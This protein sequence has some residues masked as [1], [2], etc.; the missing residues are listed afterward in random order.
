MG[1]QQEPATKPKVDKEKIKDLQQIKEKAL[2][3]KAIIKK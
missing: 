1:A 2:K 3:D